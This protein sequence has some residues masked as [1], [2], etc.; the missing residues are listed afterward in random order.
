MGT[1]PLSAVLAGRR[2]FLVDL[3][4]VIYE[5][6]RAID[7][8]REFFHHLRAH[9]MPF[10][11]ITNNST[12][13]AADVALHLQR[14]DM[15]VSESDVLTSPEATAIHVEQRCGH[16][17]CI[18]V[19]GEDGLVRTL[20]AHG[21][22]LT[23]EPDRADAVVCGLDRRLTYDRLRRACMALRRGAPLIATN[24]D[25]ALPT[26]SGF[27]PGNGATLAYLE[28]ATGVKPLVIGKPS[29]TMLQIAMA[30]MRSTVAET[31]MIG[32]GIE[33][34]ILAG[35]RAS[36]GT[37]LVLSGVTREADVANASATPGAVV[38]SIATVW[39]RLIGGHS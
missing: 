23:T 17:A 33:T 36:V 21:F 2:A 38:E 14:M 39:Q 6:A 28:A 27:L 13:T 34:D 12:R 5:G 15:P 1:D 16:G 3:D 18:F 10:H 22:T 31:V 19:I 32:D 7:G 35:A 26:E 4:G 37:I 25:R 29:P 30:R 24:P 11:V 20:I 8:A 9:R